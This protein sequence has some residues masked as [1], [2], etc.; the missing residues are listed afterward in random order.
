MSED[1]QPVPFVCVRCHC[2][3][4]WDVGEQKFMAKLVADGLMRE[5]AAPKL[6]KVCRRNRRL[7]REKM[8]RERIA[9]AAAEKLVEEA[10][11]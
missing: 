6:C 10:S 2:D 8:E 5:V 4:V 9:E 11:E 7:F 3:E 1:F